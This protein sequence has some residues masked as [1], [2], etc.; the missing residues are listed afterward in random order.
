MKRDMDELFSTGNFLPSIFST[1]FCL[2]ESK[3]FHVPVACPAGSCRR[4]KPE[5]CPVM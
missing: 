4:G 5:E 1:K 2:L 3:A